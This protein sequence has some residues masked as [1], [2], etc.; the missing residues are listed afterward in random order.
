MTA[1]AAE[2]LTA[3]EDGRRAFE[4]AAWGD[5][6]HRLSAADQETPLAPA[7]LERLA[8]AAYLIGRDAESSELWGRAHQE[9]V[10]TG[11]PERAA[12]CAFWLALLLLLSGEVARSSGWL[13]RARRLLAASAGD[14]VEVG[15]LASLDALLSLPNEGDVAASAAKFSRVRSRRVPGSATAT[16]KPLAG[17]VMAR[18]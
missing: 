10:G 8:T 3:L 6:Y 15:Y 12:R 13:G 1:D 11:E 7:D 4:C 16:W 14:C 9:L 18:V 17:W 5:A 2:G